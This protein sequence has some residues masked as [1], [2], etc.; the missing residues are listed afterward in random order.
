MLMR[1]GAL[2]LVLG[3]SGAV[4]AT[5]SQPDKEIQPAAPQERCEAQRQVFVSA[6]SE[7]ARKA[8]NAISVK[9]RPDG[10]AVLT[11]ADYVEFVYCKGAGLEVHFLDPMLPSE[12]L[13][14]GRM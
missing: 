7:S 1:L 10:V 8:G 4:Y 13:G 12:E 3:F 6:L 11:Y 5:T 9:N 14:F 2:T